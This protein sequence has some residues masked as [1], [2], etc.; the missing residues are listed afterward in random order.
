MNFLKEKLKRQSKTSIVLTVIV[1]IALIIVGQVYYSEKEFIKNFNQFKKE[2]T[3]RNDKEANKI[4]EEIKKQSHKEKVDVYILDQLE[5]LKYSLDN[6]AIEGN[7]IADPKKDLEHF[8]FYTKDSEKFKSKYVEMEIYVDDYSHYKV[9]LK[10]LD[11]KEFVKSKEEFSKVTSNYKY[12]DEAQNLI[13]DMNNKAKEWA[14]SSSQDFLALGEVEKAKQEIEK[15]LMLNK[16]ELELIKAKEEIEKNRIKYTL[17]KKEIQDTLNKIKQ[18]NWIKDE[19]N[20]VVE[21]IQYKDKN[22]YKVIEKNEKDENIW[23]YDIYIEKMIDIEEDKDS[24]QEKEENMKES[25]VILVKGEEKKNLNDYLK[26]NA[27]AE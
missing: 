21:D 13:N 18:L 23:P 2:F 25:E 15:G 16:D 7:S 14:L 24:T 6:E 11:D 3:E 20:I 4:Y 27:K 8:K 17:N 10:A 22:F 19:K 9:G 12:Y 26:E 5:A 1:I